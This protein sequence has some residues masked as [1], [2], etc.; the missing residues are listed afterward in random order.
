M[1]PKKVKTRAA[2]DASES[3]T[4]AALPKLPFGGN[5]NSGICAFCIIR[6]AYEPVKP[7]EYTSAT[8]PSGQILHTNGARKAYLIL[9]TPH[10]MAFLD[11]NPL[12]RG[13][14]LVCPVKHTRQGYGVLERTTGLD[15]RS[16]AEV[17]NLATIM[18]LSEHHFQHWPFALRQALIPPSSIALANHAS[19]G[20]SRPAS[21]STRRDESLLRPRHQRRRLKLQHRAEQRCDF[22]LR[23]THPH[24]I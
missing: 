1:A 11:I 8:F 9:R 21:D 20:R 24:T 23:P 18:P 13:H 14:L 2:S 3:A 17:R 4:A 6:D 19:P 15:S 5:L 22:T 16:A 10:V 12:V 7:S